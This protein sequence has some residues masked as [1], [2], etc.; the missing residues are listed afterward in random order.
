MMLKH[1]LNT[2]ELKIDD[3][4]DAISDTTAIQD[5]SIHQGMDDLQAELIAVKEELQQLFDLEQQ[6]EAHNPHTFAV[7]IYLKQQILGV[8]P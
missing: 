6:K 5:I 1:N 8:E 2:L 7:I 4:A 3:L